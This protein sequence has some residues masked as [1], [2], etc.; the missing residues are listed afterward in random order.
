MFLCKFSIGQTPIGKPISIGIGSSFNPPAMDFIRNNSKVDHFI[1][2]TIFPTRAEI[3]LG[4]K[5]GRKS[6][7]NITAGYGGLPNSGYA[8]TDERSDFA[9][10]YT[11]IDS[12]KLR[13]NSINIGLE[14]NLYQEFNPIGKYFSVGAG[15]S[16]IRTKVYGVINRKRESFYSINSNDVNLFNDTYHLEPWNQN[17]GVIQ[18]NFGFGNT[19]VITNRISIDYGIKHFF[20]FGLGG[21][22]T[23]NYDSFSDPSTYDY[24]NSAS[25]ITKRL[26]LGTIQNSNLF[27]LY[28]RLHYAL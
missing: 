7:I 6:R 18:I 26:Q 5:T 4:I 27:H 28:L 22:E 20:F 25:H 21:L 24:Q 10:Y 9:N 11:H 16:L 3:C 1:D 12:F 23:K 15:Y 2:E 17:T 19:S 8:I 14:L 13:N